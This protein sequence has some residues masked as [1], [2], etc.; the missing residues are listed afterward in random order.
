L[1]GC[2][3]SEDAALRA[4]YSNN[5]NNR[6]VLFY[7]QEQVNAFAKSAN[8]AGLQIA[9]HTIGDAAIEQA[10]N[11]YEAALCDFPREDHRHVLIHADLMD[12]AMIDKAASLGVAIAL[13]T[14]FL[15]WPQEPV[16][17]VQS[18]LGRRVEHLIPLKSMLEAG[19]LLASGSD[20]PCTLPDPILGIYAACNH[21]NSDER[22][23]VLDALRMHTHWGAK[24]SFDEVER[25]T[26]TVGKIAD[27]VVLDQNPLT[28]PVERL[29]NL[30]IQAVYLQG[31]RYTGQETGVTQLLIRSLN[32]KWWT[33]LRRSDRN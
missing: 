8:R 20:G 21:P 1:D 12:T 11:A 28:M 13:Q 32:A 10:L 27:F 9:M 16:E 23:S 2:F 3:G 15:Y 7:T 25:G 33:F 31:Q 18:L 26:L 30:Q 4:P 29:K 5:A 19:V 17:Y 22:L 14:P 6:G 24:L